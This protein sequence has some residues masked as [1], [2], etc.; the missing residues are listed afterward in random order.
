M[1]RADACHSAVMWEPSLDME[2]LASV[3]WAERWRV[4]RLGAEGERRE[5]SHRQAGGP[6]GQWA[7]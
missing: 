5:N 2:L 4:E 3:L 1:S 6:L 7:R